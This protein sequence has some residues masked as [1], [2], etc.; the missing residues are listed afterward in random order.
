MKLMT[1][2]AASAALALAA[3]A[4]P[5]VVAAET[6][7]VAGSNCGF[8]ANQ[9]ANGFK[10]YATFDTT[11]ISREIGGGKNCQ[12][13][14]LVTVTYTSVNRNGRVMEDR[15]V[16]EDLGTTDWGSSYKNVDGCNF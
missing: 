9:I 10:C 13:A 15:T 14:Q 7:E 2:L 5:T 6:V 3:F 11:D 1:S 12:D 8:N 16:V 4:V